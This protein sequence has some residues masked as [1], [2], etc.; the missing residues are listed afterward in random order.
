MTE[1]NRE[2]IFRSKMALF[3]DT[4]EKLADAIGMSRQT[5]SKKI[6]N[7]GWYDDEIALI[8]NRYK[9]TNDEIVVIFNLRGS[10]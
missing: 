7:G 6:T 5:L 9:L 3:D 10:N 2:L 8:S 1:L 4:V